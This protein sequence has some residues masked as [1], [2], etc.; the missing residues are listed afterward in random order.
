MNQAAD[1]LAERLLPLEGGINFRDM[2][3]YPAADGRTVRWRRL[4]RSG[5]MAR[6]TPA[7]YE[8]LAG[9]SIRTVIDLRTRTEQLDEPNAWCVAAGVT[10]WC[11]EH[12]ETF[13]NLHEMVE[14]G[15][16]TEDDA[17]AV[18]MAGY[19]HLPVQQAV[20]YA[21]LFRRIAAGEVPIVINCTA[22]KDRTGGGA[23]LVLAMLG[24]ARE[25]IAADFAMTE[26]AVDLRRAFAARPSPNVSRYASLTEPVMAALG[27][28][29]PSYITALLNAVDERFGSI[30]GYLGDLGFG[31]GDIAAM[32]A[33]LLE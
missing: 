24:V 16:T 21:E 33:E 20:A 19:R 23:A 6:L 3:G 22:G 4:Y 2:G 7:D 1:D 8:Q 10:Y 12:D 26:R 31:A 28:A 13:G 29:H 25:T 9:R 27:G 14:R 32:R 17:R 15:I 30:A 18:M 5:T 11:R